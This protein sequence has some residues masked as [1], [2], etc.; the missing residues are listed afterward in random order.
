MTASFG[1]SL[2]DTFETL[3]L[4]GEA[5][6]IYEEDLFRFYFGCCFCSFFFLGGGGGGDSVLILWM[7]YLLFSF[8]GRGGDKAVSV[9]NYSELSISSC[10]HTTHTHVLYVLAK[11][12]TTLYLYLIF[13]RRLCTC[14]SPS[15]LY[16]ST[17]TKVVTMSVT[18]HTKWVQRIISAVYRITKEA[19]S[20]RRIL[21]TALLEDL[22]YR[23]AQFKT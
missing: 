7:G 11:Y 12:F 16:F 10:T 5:W 14:V 3:F 1:L 6:D 17:C 4:W 21:W 15:V 23:W 20:G 19:F 2:R 9:Q 8:W 18:Y 13:N 22:Y